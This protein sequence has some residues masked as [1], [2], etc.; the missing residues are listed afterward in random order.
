M[1][2]IILI[3]IISLLLA[4]TAC[5]QTIDKGNV[6]LKNVV[7]V[8]IKDFSFMPKDLVIKKGTIVE[9][10]NLD[11]TVHTATSVGNFDSGKLNPGEKWSFTFNDVKKYEYA[12]YFHPSMKATIEVTE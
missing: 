1:K 10:T 7:N 11:N 4:M 5:T 6:Q 2:K 3:I 8:E 9:W 12:C